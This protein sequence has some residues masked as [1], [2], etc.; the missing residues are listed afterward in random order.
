LA[1][2]PARQISTPLERS[3]QPLQFAQPLRLHVFL[4]QESKPLATQSLQRF[5]PDPHAAVSVPSRH[6]PEESQQ[7]VGHVSALQ[8]PGLTMVPLSSVSDSRLDR[9]HPG[10]TTTSKSAAS[11]TETKNVAKRESEGRRIQAS[12]R[13]PA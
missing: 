10:A 13:D 2:A 11:A 9:P 7:P 3:Q 4:S 5:P 12:I 6:V 1:S 8:E